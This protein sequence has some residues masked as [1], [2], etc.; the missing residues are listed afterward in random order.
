MLLFFQFISKILLLNL[1]QTYCVY[2]I[3]L[4]LAAF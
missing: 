4:K 3:S 2:S 1:I